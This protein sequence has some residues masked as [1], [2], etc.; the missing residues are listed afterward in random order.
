MFA[1]YINIYLYAGTLQLCVM[2]KN[3]LNALFFLIFFFYQL[4]RE[5]VTAILSTYS[6]TA[7][8]IFS[9]SNESNGG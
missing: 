1:K 5:A 6:K 4:K 9:S 2:H 7:L 3:T 8:A